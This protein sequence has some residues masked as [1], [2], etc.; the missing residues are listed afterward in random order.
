M[1]LSVK[2]FST[3]ATRVLVFFL[4]LILFC[5]PLLILPDQSPPRDFLFLMTVW[6]VIIGV[7]AAACRLGREDPAPDSPLDRDEP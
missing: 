4:A 2:F 6:A 5:G 3:P 7:L 1:G